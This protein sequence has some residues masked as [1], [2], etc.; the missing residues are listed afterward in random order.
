MLR[1]ILKFVGDQAPTY[2]QDQHSLV[3]KGAIAAYAWYCFIAAWRHPD[4][5]LFSWLTLYTIVTLAAGIFIFS[6][7]SALLDKYVIQK[8]LTLAAVEDPP[9]Q[10]GSSGGGGFGGA[11]LLSS[12]MGG[13]GDGGASPFGMGFPP[14]GAAGGAPPPRRAPQLN[15]KL[16]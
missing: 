6:E 8:L 2:L 9:A 13:G 11:S 3:M 12:L 15:E 16:D 10:V 4:G 14:S 1:T 5:G 7:L